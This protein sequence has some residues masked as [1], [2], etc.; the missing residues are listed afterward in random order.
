[1]SRCSGVCGEGCKMIGPLD[2]GC[3][4]ILCCFDRCMCVTDSQP[5]SIS[6]SGPL[7]SHRKLM[8]PNPLKVYGVVFHIIKVHYLLAKIRMKKKQADTFLSYH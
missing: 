7:P 4:K 6:I 5:Y 1:M 8:P 2:K 3:H